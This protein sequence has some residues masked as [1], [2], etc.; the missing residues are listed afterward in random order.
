MN[1]SLNVMKKTMV[2]LNHILDE[3]AN[4]IGVSPIE[5]ACEH[6]DVCKE[7]GLIDSSFDVQDFL[8]NIGFSQNEIQEYLEEQ[9]GITNKVLEISSVQDI[10]DYLEDEH[11]I[12]VHSYKNGS[13]WELELEFESDLGEDVLVYIEHDNTEQSIIN[14]IKEYAEYFDAEE[15]AE[16]W[17][18]SRGR[19]GV[20]NSILDLIEDA[21]SI[22]AF[23]TDIANEL[24]NAHI[25]EETQEL[26]IQEDIEK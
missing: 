24:S 4:N 10:I 22:K 1:K 7:N 12:N 15:H 6:Y 26:N 23:L 20:P 5:L 21:K 25:I 2:V 8:T 16:C 13:E 19:N 17:I 18:D 3:Y 9:N 14:G 11:Y